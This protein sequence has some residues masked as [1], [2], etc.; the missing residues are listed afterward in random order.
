MK[1]VGV[2]GGGGGVVNV[3]TNCNQ[4]LSIKIDHSSIYDNGEKKVGIGVGDRW[5]KRG[6]KN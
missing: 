1:W 2:G 3:I 6:S 5:G 4:S